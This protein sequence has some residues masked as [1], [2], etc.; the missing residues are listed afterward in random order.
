MLRDELSRLVAQ[1]LQQLAHEGER[2]CDVS[3]DVQPSMAFSHVIAITLEVF[4]TMLESNC[5]RP[6]NTEMFPISHTRAINAV[7]GYVGM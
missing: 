4:T 1:Q 6:K 3:K 5:K 7:F 2:I